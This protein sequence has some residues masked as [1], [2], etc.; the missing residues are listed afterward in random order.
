MDRCLLQEV[1]GGYRLHDLILQYLQHTIKMG[2][3][4]LAETAI[5][6]QARYLGRHDVI[7]KYA[8]RGRYNSGGGIYSL[9][10][11]WTALKELDD[12][13]DAGECHER[14]L[15]GVIDMRTRI[16]VGWLLYLLVRRS[17]GIFFAGLAHTW[18]FVLDIESPVLV[19]RRSLCTCARHITG[20]LFK[21]GV[22]AQTRPA[23]G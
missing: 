9:I 14:S 20:Q 19:W 17:L 5:S 13:L 3:Q 23:G 8:A 4:G 6:R 7:N 21:C 18:T 15:W 10:T 1:A 16:D 11:L 2:D 12:T 22:G